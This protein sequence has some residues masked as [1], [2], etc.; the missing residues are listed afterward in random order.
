MAGR[1]HRSRR[2]CIRKRR[3]ERRHGRKTVRRILG[4][5]PQDGTPHVR[6]QSLAHA[7]E[8]R[9]LFVQ[10]HAQEF[11]H[12]DIT[13][14]PQPAEQLEREDAKRILVGTAV[15]LVA[16]PLLGRHVRRR[17][18]DSRV[19]SGGGRRRVPGEGACDA[20]VR[21][22]GVP[23]FRKQDVRRLDVPMYNA[24]SVRIVQRGG[25]LAQQSNR[26]LGGN[27]ALVG[28]ERFQAAA[29]DETHGVKRRAVALPNREDR[30][31]MRV[32]EPGRETRLTLEARERLGIEQGIE[33]EHL[34]RDFPVERHFPRTED[35]AHAAAPDERAQLVG[36]ADLRLQ[37]LPHTLS[38]LSIVSA[39]RNDR[40]A[41]RAG[42]G[43]RVERD[44]ALRTLRGDPGGR[45]DGVERVGSAGSVGHVAGTGVILSTSEGAFLLEGPEH[46]Q[47]CAGRVRAVQR[48]TPAG[49]S[50]C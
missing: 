47:G 37:P 20:K 10:V 39:A 41:P 3:H 23:A 12:R 32:I 15:G 50:S 43:E 46:P 30:H 21:H 44:A 5:G 16:A 14:R 28:D 4:H 40:A 48:S 25:H 2:A 31:D 42:R 17:P 26:G 1:R 38:A 19:R 9:R 36:V 35:D 34:E 45:G 22:Q 29:A 24:L 49:N 11:L 6:R 33:C 13:E 7:V 18:Y 8:L 27:R